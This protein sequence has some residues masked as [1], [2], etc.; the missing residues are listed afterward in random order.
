MSYN[1]PYIIGKSSSKL[2]FTTF[3]INQ[4]AGRA[5]ETTKDLYTDCDGR[6]MILLRRG[7]LLRTKPQEYGKRGGGQ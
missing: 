4:Y 2:L 5:P 1:F 7:S 6:I 3:L